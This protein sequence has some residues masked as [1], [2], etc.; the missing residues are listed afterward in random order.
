MFVICWLLHPDLRWRATITDLE[1]NEWINQAVDI[2]KY[3]FDAV[4]G[5]YNCMWRI[6]AGMYPGVV[7]PPFL[8][9]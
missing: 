1:E 2:T 3:S 6:P 7:E 4:M 8:A 5:Q 9:D